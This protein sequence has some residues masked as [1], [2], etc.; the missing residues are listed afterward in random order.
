M[1]KRTSGRHVRLMGLAVFVA[2]GFGSAASAQSP[3]PESR[4]AVTQAIFGGADLDYEVEPFDRL[5]IFQGCILFLDGSKRYCTMQGI[6]G[7]YLNKDQAPWQVQLSTNI[8]AK[9]YSAAVLEKY[10]LWELNHLCGG[11]LIAPNWILTAAH[12]I[13]RDDMRRYGLTARLGVGD[14]SKPEGVAFKID[15]AI[16]H[17]DYDPKTKL[18]DIALLHFVDHR[19]DGRPLSALGIETITLHGAL[20][21]GP[22]LKPE[23]DLITMGWGVT[24]TGPDGRNSKDLLGFRLN[25]MPNDFCAQAL[26]APER[27]NASVICAIGPG[28]DACQGDSGGPLN[29]AVYRIDKQRVVSVQVG[30]VSWG[31]GCAIPGNPGVYTRVSAHLGWIRRAMA[32]PSD[33]SVLR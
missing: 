12:C 23:E 25:R 10:P 31:K 21:E 14:L 5:D 26:K 3:Q 7:I 29:S 30:I 2:L 11:S 8:P 22:R 24:S 1:P 16:V 32:A 17:Q 6:R 4:P 33:V 13:K 28:T 9:E 27:I 18:N 15:R 19:T 20:A